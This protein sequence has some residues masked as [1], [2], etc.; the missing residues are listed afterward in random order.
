MDLISGK[1]NIFVADSSF[2]HNNSGMLFHVKHN[3]WDSGLNE[4]VLIAKENETD[5]RDEHAFF[6]NEYIGFCGKRIAVVDPSFRS[7]PS[8]K[9]IKLDYVIISKQP[10]IKIRELLRTL[11]A[12]KIIF[13]SSNP[14]WKVKRWMAECKALSVSCYDVAGSGAFVEDIVND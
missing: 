9:K 10:R 7:H 11:D 6:K 3:W 12:G 4:Q 14:Q 2:L 8:G 5:H 1:K 13:D